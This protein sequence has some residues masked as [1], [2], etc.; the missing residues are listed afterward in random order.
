[1]ALLDFQV[2]WLGPPNQQG[3]VCVIRGRP[4][5]GASAVLKGAPLAPLRF[6]HAHSCLVAC[7]VQEAIPVSMSRGKELNR[8]SKS[9]QRFG[10]H[11]LKPQIDTSTRI[12]DLTSYKD[13]V[14]LGN[15]TDSRRHLHRRTKKIA[16]LLDGFAGMYTDPYTDRGLADFVIRCEFLLNLNCTRD[17]SRCIAKRCHSA[18]TR[19]FYLGAAMVFQTPPDDRVVSPDQCHRHRIAELRRHLG[20]T[21]HVREHDGAEG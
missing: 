11:W 13:R 6:L 8:F 16:A 3:A 20:R 18:V 15:I 1:R 10:A 5:Q 9:L 2:Q 4:S 7:A 19:V 14:C 12:P 17:R 21:D